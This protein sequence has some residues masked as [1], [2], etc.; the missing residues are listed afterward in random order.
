M[1]PLRARSSKGGLVRAARP[2]LA[3]ARSTVWGTAESTDWS[4]RVHRMELVP[5]FRQK[6]PSRI[7]PDLDGPPLVL[8]IPVSPSEGCAASASP[9]ESRLS[10]N[11]ERGEEA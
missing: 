6:D 5:R 10:S 4:R 8:Q 2:P 7:P 3:R 11:G 9:W 1:D